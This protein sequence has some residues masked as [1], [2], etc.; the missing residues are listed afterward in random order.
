MEKFNSQFRGKREADSEAEPEAVRGTRQVLQSA[1]GVTSIND[2]SVNELQGLLNSVNN[3]I[4]LRDSHGSPPALGSH[5]LDLSLLSQHQQQHGQ[6]SESNRPALGM[7]FEP[8]PALTLVDGFQPSQAAFHGSRA[9]SGGGLLDLGSFHNTLSVEPKSEDL[10]QDVLLQDPVV[11]DRLQSLRMQQPTEVVEEEKMKS[12]Q[13]SGLMSDAELLALMSSP[14]VAANLDKVSSMEDL[15]ALIN[16]ERTRQGNSGDSSNEEVERGGKS[17]PLD[18][19]QS[20]ENV[21]SATSNQNPFERQL[22]LS[23]SP[24]VQE[25][26]LARTRIVN[27]LPSS[28]NFPRSADLLGSLS[29][30]PT[31]QPFHNTLPFHAS[32]PSPRPTLASL[33]GSLEGLGGLG[34]PALG[35]P[36]K[37][38]LGGSVSDPHNSALGSLVVGK[39]DATKEDLVNKVIQHLKETQ[40]LLAFPNS[41]TLGKP[42]PI[43]PSVHVDHHAH[44]HHPKPLLVDLPDHPPHSEPHPPLPPPTVT[45]TEVPA[46]YGC[47]AYSTKTCQKVPVIVPEKVPV[48]RCYD[49]PKVECFQVLAPVPDLECAPRAHED[50]VDIVNEVISSILGTRQYFLLF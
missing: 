11:Q 48:P 23:P 17:L 2:L 7:A 49:V 16:A 42:N 18:D 28:I 13:D 32:L 5:V 31:A 26:S 37:I 50:C 46:P 19:S 34:K 6:H 21:L 43:L 30:S 45:K 20:F 29:G 8:S 47:K 24:S 9:S 33:V 38:P 15:V 1:K 44:D 40:P 41:P 36:V 14:M 4:L 27:N 10:S 3:G 39:A 35:G 22:L 25:G 12:E